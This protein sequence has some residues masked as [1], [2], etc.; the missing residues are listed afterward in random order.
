MQGEGLDLAGVDYVAHGPGVGCRE[1]I[2]AQEVSADLRRGHYRPLRAVP[3]L[4]QGP[5]NPA[6]VE[7]TA[8]RPN[9]VARDCRYPRE[10]APRAGVG[11]LPASTAC[12]PSAGSGFSARRSYLVYAHRPHVVGRDRAHGQELPARS[13]VGGG[14]DRPLRAVPVHSER[15]VRT[16]SRPL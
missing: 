15:F 12:R 3:V 14:N 11:C 10:L 4:D 8:H 1:S 16:G 13:R 6:R 7:I 2:G 9:V 5:V